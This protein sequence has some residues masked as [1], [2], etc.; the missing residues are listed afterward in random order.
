MNLQ[1]FLRRMAA[2]SPLADIPVTVRRGPIRGARW[3]LFPFSMYWRSGGDTEVATA[4][5]RLRHLAGAVFWDFGAHFGIHTIGMSLKVGPAGQ[6]VA[7]EPDPFSFAKLSR[8][9]KLNHLHNV[10]LFRAGVSSRCGS[11][12]IITYGSGASTQHFAYPDDGGLRKPDQPF[13]IVQTVR[14]DDLV[15][16]QEIRPPD[17]I[18]VDVEGHGGSAL[19]GS[20][21]SIA[22]RR[23]IIV[24]SSHSTME[25]VG[26]RK[27]LEPLGYHVHAI[28]GAALS[29]DQLTYN[30]RILLPA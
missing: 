26:A 14:A 28:D 6:V 3:T 19:E 9:V 1:S 18:K 29:W 10:R 12:E 2:A 24:M 13:F 21:R 16:N 30:T 15:A 4:A 22:D 17:L 11:G 8:H 20:S 5:S 25:T 7:F 27:V 23:P